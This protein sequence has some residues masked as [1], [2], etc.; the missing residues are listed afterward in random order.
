MLKSLVRDAA[1][2]L[3]DDVQGLGFIGLQPMRCD[4]SYDHFKPYHCGRAESNHGAQSQQ[5]VILREAA[6]CE[7]NT[8]LAFLLLWK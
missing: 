3:P 2:V 4:C 1:A 5:M 7:I 6:Y 8:I